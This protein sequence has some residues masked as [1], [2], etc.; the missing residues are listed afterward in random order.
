MLHLSGIPEILKE[1]L[2]YFY[3]YITCSS[4]ITSTLQV[5]WS[6]GKRILKHS[7]EERTI[8]LK[9]LLEMQREIETH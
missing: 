8:V 3:E 6:L 2:S 5:K 4:H 9:N 1:N 7:K